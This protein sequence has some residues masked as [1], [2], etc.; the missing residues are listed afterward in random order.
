[1]P[2]MQ[3]LSYFVSFPSHCRGGSLSAPAP[4]AE[5]RA[6]AEV[7]DLALTAAEMEW[8]DLRRQER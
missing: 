4:D 7:F 5:C 2:S 1:M 8:L 6:N 3:S